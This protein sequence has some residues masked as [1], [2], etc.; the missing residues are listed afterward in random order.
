MPST[1]RSTGLSAPASM[2][3]RRAMEDRTCSAPSFSPLDLTA[4]EHICGQGLQH[5]FLAEVEAQ[6]FHVSYQPALSMAGCG[7]RL[8]ERAAVPG[9]RGQS[10]SS[11]IYIL[12]TPCVDYSQE[13]PAEATIHRIQCGE[14]GAQSPQSQDV[15]P[16]LR[17]FWLATV[18]SPHPPVPRPHSRNG[19]GSPVAHQ[20]RRFLLNCRTP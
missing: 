6:G 20:R 10:C 7:E 11:W 3:R 1:W 8:G 17:A 18:F 19:V 2:P 13:Q 16:C 12:R 9:N 15:G 5:G 4:L 14:Y